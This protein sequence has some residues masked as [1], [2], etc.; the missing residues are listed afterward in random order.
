MSRAMSETQK[1]R[2][3]VLEPQLDKAL[4]NQDLQAAKRAVLDIQ[5]LLRPTKHYVRLVQSKNKL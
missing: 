3:G 4:R 1:A 5:D 2:L